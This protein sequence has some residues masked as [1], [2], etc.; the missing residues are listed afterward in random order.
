MY[1]LYKALAF[2]IQSNAE[3]MKAGENRVKILLII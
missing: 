3:K 1:V 2:L